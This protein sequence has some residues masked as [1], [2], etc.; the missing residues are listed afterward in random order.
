MRAGNILGSVR[1]ESDNAMI[2]KAFVFTSDFSALTTTTDFNF[3]VGRRGTGKSAL[4]QKVLEY[5][6]K[7]P[8]VIVAAETPE[9]HHAT[10][11]QEAL[12]EVTT[13]YRTARSIMKVAWRCHCLMTIAAKIASHHKARTEPEDLLYIAQYLEK[14]QEL[15]RLVTSARCAKVVRTYSKDYEAR[16]VPAR[17]ASEL[18]IDR[19]EAT[20]KRLLDATGLQA[21]L[22]MDRLDEGWVPSAVATAILGGL[23]TSASAFSDR[24]CSL[25]VLLFIRDNMFRSLSHLDD[26]FS[27]AIEGNALRLHWTEDDLFHLVAERLRVALGAESVE[28]D[29]KIWNRFAQRTLKDREGF[30]QCLRHTLRR[31]RDILV[32]LNGAYVVATRQKRAAIIET[33]L[34]ATATRVSVERLDDLC[35]EYETV[36][37]GLRSFVQLFKNRAPRM[38]YASVL[39]TVQEGGDAV[40]FSEPGDSDYAILNSP[41]DIFNALYG[42]GFLGIKDATGGYQFC[43]DGAPSQGTVTPD[44]EIAVHPCYWRALALEEPSLEEHLSVEVSDDYANN[45]ATE[46]RDLRTRQLGKTIDDLS[47]IAVGHDGQAAFE[48]W[49][50]RAFKI[51]FS[52]SLSNLQMKPNGSAIQRRD[53]VGT[54]VAERGFWARVMHDYSPRQQIVEVKNYDETTP[55]DYRQLSGYLTRDYGNLGIMVTRAEREGLNANERGWV[56]EIYNRE[57]KLLFIVPAMLLAKFL[58]KKRSERKHNYAEDQLSKRLDTFVRSYCADKHEVGRR[59]GRRGSGRKERSGDSPQ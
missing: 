10:A 12:K 40:T 1:A 54:N 32:L 16:Q 9:D 36:L 45:S 39:E 13:E 47:S 5:L 34:E 17:I 20:I 35:R 58:R 59:R 42:V 22:L 37:P 14:H 57:H 48:T 3:V 24:K 52:G 44:W 2:D 46:I 31:P 21:Y 15:A 6:L 28:N 8:N 33:D 30:K 50:F 23:A 49:V 41:A 26:D 53:I 4:F 18:E 51:L 19:L 43:H 11:L 25:H 27:R 38:T 56:K 7:R 29:N 55:D